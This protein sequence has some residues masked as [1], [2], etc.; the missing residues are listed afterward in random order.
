MTAEDLAIAVWVEPRY[1][2]EVSFLEWTRGGSLR[3]ARIK[4]IPAE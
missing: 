4:Q 3:H 1:K 2:A